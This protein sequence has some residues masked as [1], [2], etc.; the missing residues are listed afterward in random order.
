MLVNG[1]LLGSGRF[2]GKHAFAGLSI[3]GIAV[4]VATTCQAGEVVFEAV[5][6]YSCSTG[7]R[8]ILREMT[9]GPLP[10]GSI[11]LSGWSSSRA[12][13]WGEGQ[14]CF[15]ERHRTA[16]YADPYRWIR[17]ESIQGENRQCGEPAAW[18][19]GHR[20]GTV[21]V[22]L[23][24]GIEG[25]IF[26]EGCEDIG[27]AW[28]YT[29]LKGDFYVLFFRLWPEPC[30]NF[31]FEVLP[32]NAAQLGTVKNNYW[33]GAGVGGI[34]VHDE[35]QLSCSGYL[36]PGEYLLSRSSVTVSASIDAYCGSGD[37]DFHGTGTASF[38][39]DGVGGGVTYDPSDETENA[40]PVATFACTLGHV[41]ENAIAN[42]QIG[43]H[44]VEDGWEATY[45]PAGAMYTLDATGSYDPDMPDAADNGI[46]SYAW[47]ITD[48][49]G[50]AVDASI[51]SLGE[52]SGAVL[53][54]H[55]GQYDIALTVSDHAGLETTTSKTVSVEF[56]QVCLFGGRFSNNMQW[57][58]A[59]VN[60]A[61]V[62]ILTSGAAGWPDIHILYRHEDKFVIWD[63]FL[64]H[65]T[66]PTS[67]GKTY[68]YVTRGESI[69]AVAAV[70]AE[71]ARTHPD[72][73]DNAIIV[74]GYEGFDASTMTYTGA[75]GF[76]I[77]AQAVIDALYA[78]QSL[79]E[80]E[81]VVGQG[82]TVG[83]GIPVDAGATDLRAALSWPGSLLVL[84]LTA[85]DGRTHTSTPGQLVG[86]S[87]GATHHAVV[88]RDPMPG[89]WQLDVEGIEVAPGGEDYGLVVGASTA[90][91]LEAEMEGDSTEG[92]G[93]A[94]IRAELSDQAQVVDAVSVSATIVRPDTGKVELPL[95]LESRGADS[96]EQGLE[97]SGEYAE[98]SA[99]GWYDVK[100]VAE[101]TLADGSKFVRTTRTRFWQGP[102]GL[103]VSG[104]AC[105]GNRE[106]D[107]GWQAADARILLTNN[108]D[109]DRWIV[110]HFVGGAHRNDFSARRPED[111]SLH[112]RGWRIPAGETIE[113]PWYFRPSE[114]G[115]REATINF[116]CVD[117]LGRFLPTQSVAVTGMGDT[118]SV[119]GA[120]FLRGPRCGLLSIHSLL[121]VCLGMTQLRRRRRSV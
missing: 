111:E 65:L 15:Y 112:E 106:L 48:A 83:H 94:T 38:V 54:R 84:R 92:S 1:W 98:S 100:V 45:V 105:A 90:L 63:G 69:G 44:R 89:T 10:D 4:L 29:E 85:P 97:F 58:T 114:T 115:L 74:G 81:G 49:D 96:P 39:L 31:W 41:T 110:T 22:C 16:W 2:E 37:A 103:T 77:A 51:V 34:P 56:P 76:A 62:P 72:W 95:M 93:R 12:L 55:A 40:P 75:S 78:A 109:E 13:D 52:S 20:G 101:G 108:S 91:R 3:V 6:P 82:E 87:T 35:L 28:G 26:A 99:R 47:S 102:T 25:K 46:V 11:T 50:N 119:P 80:V 120:V 64:E 79:S 5:I 21:S 61:I 24:V 86:E 66:T 104:S 53:F 30:G 71:D 73:P 8:R 43:W 14:N 7:D 116:I 113:W 118:A 57:G 70:S 121:V 23:S 32:D 117:A 19:F 18:V 17:T 27:D 9:Y 33:S 42:V 68:F 36:P 107:Q 67:R 88:I 59:S 60:G